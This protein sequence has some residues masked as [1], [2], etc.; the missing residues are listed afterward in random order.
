MDNGIGA[1]EKLKSKMDFKMWK[2]ILAVKSISLT[3]VQTKDLKCAFQFNITL[4]ICSKS[5]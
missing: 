3:L 1:T 2:T 4:V 5:Y